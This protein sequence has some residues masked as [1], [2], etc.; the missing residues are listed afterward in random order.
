M[1]VRRSSLLQ[2]LWLSQRQVS[3][4]QAHSLAVSRSLIYQLT[5]FRA[6]LAFMCL[7]CFRSSGFPTSS[8]EFKLRRRTALLGSLGSPVVAY[9]LRLPPA[10]LGT[11]SP[12]SHS[13]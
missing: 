4:Y 7:V 2:S 3:T 9:G 8:L 11:G 10:R 5:G 6:L 12:A 13:S 1:Q